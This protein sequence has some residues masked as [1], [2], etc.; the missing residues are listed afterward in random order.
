MCGKRERGQQ[1][2]Q[3]IKAP[4]S[5]GLVHMHFLE[6][7]DKDR[8]KGQSKGERNWLM[9]FV[10]IYTVSVYIDP[11]C[12]LYVQ[13]VSVREKTFQKQ[14]LGIVCKLKSYALYVGIFQEAVVT[15]HPSSFISLFV[16]RQTKNFFNFSPTPSPCVEEV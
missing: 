11:S 13:G 2:K 7:A 8:G 5:A 12:L 14:S 15:F 6:W 16:S 10:K 1:C 3:V 4:L 9:Y